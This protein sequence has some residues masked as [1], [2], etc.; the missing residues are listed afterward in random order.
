M[1]LFYGI[2]KLRK[3]KV[4][5]GKDHCNACEQE[6]LVEKWRWFNWFHIFWIPLIP[7][8]YGHNWMCTLCDQD[9]NARYKTDIYRK[10]FISVVLFAIALLM[11]QPGVIDSL[12][13]GL[14]VKILSILFFLASVVWVIKHKKL[15]SKDT[16]RQNITPVDVS[17]CA[18]CN[19]PLSMSPTLSCISCKAQVF[20][21][22]D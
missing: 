9:A 17:I 2:K 5:Y 12:E 4:G 18:Y 8:G 19:N 3:K 22:I 15:P 1:I 13:Y 14:I 6:A 11:F 20:T 7:L 21:K 10:V 16:Y